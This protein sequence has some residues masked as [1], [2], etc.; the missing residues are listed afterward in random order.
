MSAV[1][2]AWIPYL[3]RHPL[4]GISLDGMSAV[5]LTWWACLLIVLLLKNTSLMHFG[6]IS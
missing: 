5:L 4:M 6:C 1:L 2:L 3:V